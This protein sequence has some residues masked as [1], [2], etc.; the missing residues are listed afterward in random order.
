[1]RPFRRAADAGSTPRSGGLEIDSRYGGEGGFGVCAKLDAQLIILGLPEGRG[2]RDGHSGELGRGRG[3]DAGMPVPSRESALCDGH[4]CYTDTSCE[5][6]CGGAQQ[7]PAWG[8][9]CR[10]ALR[11]V[12]AGSMLGRRARSRVGEEVKGALE[13]RPH[14]QRGQRPLKADGPSRLGEGAAPAPVRRPHGLCK[15]PDSAQS[16]SGATGPFAVDGGHA[17]VH[18]QISRSPCSSPG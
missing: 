2:G 10:L 16:G 15:V 9:G 5:I 17:F 4:G 14:D 12:L 8:I 7:P 18:A 1:M 6:C 3:L 11:G 13:L